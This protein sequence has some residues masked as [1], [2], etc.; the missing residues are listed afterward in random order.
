M[1][2]VKL[3]QLIQGEAHRDAIHIA[4]AP[5]VSD[6]MVFPGQH[7]ILVD[8]KACPVEGV[9]SIG[10]VDPFLGHAV[11]PGQPF[12]LCLHP[13]SITGLRHE[14]SH[15]A[16]NKGA[17]LSPRLALMASHSKE[18]S[19][20]WLRDYVRR[21]CPYNAPHDGFDDFIER[22]KNREVF[23]NGSDCHSF[24]DVDQ[25]YELRRHLAVLG[26]VIDWSEF[27]YSCTC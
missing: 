14:W 22:V 3:G 4:V 6:V 23:Y 2:D 24:S 21:N 1:S 26:I 7:L 17:S 12:W 16:F 10:I 19:E 20:A 25:P 8:G 13:G 11:P 15:P 5:V 27:T 9:K 18:E